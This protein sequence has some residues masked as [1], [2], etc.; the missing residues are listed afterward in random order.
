ML[1]SES[2][3]PLYDP[4]TLYQQLLAEERSCVNLCRRAAPTDTR[5]WTWRMS[6]GADNRPTWGISPAAGGLLLCTRLARFSPTCARLQGPTLKSW[7]WRKSSQW[8]GMLR[9]H[10]QVVLQDVEVFRK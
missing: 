9:S 4:L 10:V 7:H 1:L 5:R 8:F 2:D 6:V 3:I